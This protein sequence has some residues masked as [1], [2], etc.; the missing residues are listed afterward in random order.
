MPI[1]SVLVG[2]VEN[3][4][5]TANTLQ[6]S[7]QVLARERDYMGQSIDIRVMQ[8]VIAPVDE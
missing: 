4:R 6:T 5:G 7:Y 2:E 3:V 8:P 1:I